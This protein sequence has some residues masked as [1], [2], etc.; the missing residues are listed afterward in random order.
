MTEKTLLEENSKAKI[1]NN[2]E[3][4]KSKISNEEQAYK[5]LLDEEAIQDTR[6]GIGP[7]RSKWLQV[8]QIFLPKVKRGHQTSSQEVEQNGLEFTFITFLSFLF[9]YLSYFSIFLSIARNSW[10]LN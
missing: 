8:G 5:I 3:K 7:F 4:G 6:C 1:V 9:F 2:V 10:L